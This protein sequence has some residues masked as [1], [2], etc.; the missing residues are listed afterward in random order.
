MISVFIGIDLGG[1]NLKSVL[2][3]SN[4]CLLAE[5]ECLTPKK[6]SELI[7]AI[8]KLSSELCAGL[9]AVAYQKVALGIGIPGIFDVSQG[10]VSQM[11]NLPGWEGVP[12]AQNLARE[13]GLPVFIDNDVNVMAIGEQ[14]FGSAQNVQDVLCITLGTG[15][16]G[17]WILNGTIYRGVSYAA[18]EI[19]HMNLIQNGLQCGC[20]N[21]GCL[22][23]YTGN[24]GFMTWLEAD[25]SQSP[26][27]SILSQWVQQGKNLSPKLITEAAKM[28][29]SFAL[30]TWKKYAT[31]LGTIL[32]GV[33]NL[34]NPELI[35]VG[36]GIAEAGK[37]LFDPLN[38]VIKARAMKNHGEHIQIV[39]A[40]LGNK[41]GKI[42]AAALAMEEIRKG[43]HYLK[44]SEL[45]KTH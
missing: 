16:G 4:G 18:G 43:T 34:M 12:L 26:M 41:A 35:V 38:Q 42:G 36:G 32:A 6:S 24:K 23:A 40:G 7:P 1:T 33:V 27:N 19:G 8:I 20:G 3:D 37:F 30:Q 2:L 45:L 25:L 13:L 15:V 44:N 14:K 11:V 10:V 5:K 9:E 21:F 22:E 31:Y 29:D 39:K 17:A 28:N